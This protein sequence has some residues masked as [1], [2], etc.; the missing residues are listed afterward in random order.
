MPE[1]P[2]HA[3]VAAALMTHRV[4]VSASDVHGSLTGYLCAGGRTDAQSWLDVLQLD[5]DDPGIAQAPILQRLYRACCAQLDEGDIDVQPLLPSR[6]LPVAQR[7]DALVEWCRGFL[8]G[9]GLGGASQRATLSAQA[10]D[11]LGDFAR[12]A[13]ARIDHAD[14]TEDEAALAE[15]LQFAI[16]GAV[17]LH[18]QVNA[19]ASK[20]SLH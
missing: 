18:A 14:D 11:V 1:S 13:A 2:T 20:R 12:V 9:F 4:G 10:C 6:T 5:S 16:D 8:G 15:V 19:E 7:A 3:E 17:L